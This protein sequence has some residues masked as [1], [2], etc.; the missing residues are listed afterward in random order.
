MVSLYTWSIYSSIVI[1]HGGTLQ[2][3]I[4]LKVSH[5]APAGSDGS[6]SYSFRMDQIWKYSPRR[7]TLEV[8]GKDPITGNSITLTGQFRVFGHQ[9]KNFCGVNMI[10][11]GTNPISK[12]DGYM[13]YVAVG[14]TESFTCK[15]DKTEENDSCK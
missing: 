13:E 6:F 15:I 2:N 4:E 8:E 9:E 14:S 5:F 7:C 10:N 1:G 11:Y 12:E 3:Y